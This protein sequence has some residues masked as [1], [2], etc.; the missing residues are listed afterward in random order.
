MLYHIHVAGNV[1]EELIVQV[2]EGILSAQ[3]NS[4]NITIYHMGVGRVRRERKS[5][6][7]QLL[8]LSHYKEICTSL[9]SQ[10]FPA[11]Q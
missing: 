1:Y 5:K 9:Y 10:I 8:K 4:R 2:C 6:F 11:I 3:H 7:S